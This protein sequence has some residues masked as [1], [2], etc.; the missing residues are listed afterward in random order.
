MVG[1]PARGKSYMA[2]KLAGYLKWVGVSTKVF[3]VGEYRR[4]RIGKSKNYQF[5]SSDN[6]TGN[7][8][9]LHMSI[10]ALD[11]M[12]HWLNQGGSVAIYDASNPTKERRKMI[13][14]RCIQENLEVVFIESLSNDPAIVERN[15]LEIKLSSPDYQDMNPEAAVDDF[16]KRLKEYERIYEPLDGNDSNLTFVKIIDMGRQVIINKVESYL[17]TRVVHFL[18]NLH[19]KSSPIWM[20]RTGESEYDLTNRIGGDPEL[21]D[22]GEEYAHALADWVSANVKDDDL[23][24]WT[25]SL[26]RATSTAQYIS[27]PKVQLRPLQDVDAGTCD[28]MT[29]EEMATVMPDEFEARVTNKLRYR[30][31]HGESYMDVIQRLEPVLFELERQRKPVLIVSHQSVLR[32]IYSYFL[33]IPAG[34]IPFVP[35]EKHCVYE[36]I[37]KA[38]QC[39]VKIHHLKVTM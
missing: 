6:E 23:Q 3:N 29:N 1:L 25:S 8:V 36:L 15:I 28:G 39:D 19:I 32:C 21:T 26:K 37:P 14:N 20:T 13:L 33:D 18:M 38:Y 17:A 9:R 34:E 24:V 31:P 4:E 5:F 12:L 10:A 30:F 22:K 7:R 16:K 27:Y 11:D 2:S 35:I